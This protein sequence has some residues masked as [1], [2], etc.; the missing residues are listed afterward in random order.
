M[1]KTAD[2]VFACFALV[3]TLHGG[4]NTSVCLSAHRQ[5]RNVTPF[6]LSSFLIVEEK[7]WGRPPFLH[8]FFPCSRELNYG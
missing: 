1:S 2:T 7:S 5:H 6:S 4:N 3:Y 8:F